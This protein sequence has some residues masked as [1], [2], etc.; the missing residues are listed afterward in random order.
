M[1][2]NPPPVEK[3]HQPVFRRSSNKSTISCVCKRA[4]GK[5][6]RIFNGPGDTDYF[7]PMNWPDGEPWKRVFNRPE[8]HNGLFTSE[9]M[10]R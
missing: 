1:P 10:I 4:Y 7:Y 2:L 8:N 6:V 5:H 3:L 9:W